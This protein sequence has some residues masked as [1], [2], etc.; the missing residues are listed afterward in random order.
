MYLV[1]R[2]V[3]ADTH[4]FQVGSRISLLE[5]WTFPVQESRVSDRMWEAAGCSS[6]PEYVAANARGRALIAEKHSILERGVGPIAPVQVPNENGVMTTK[7]FAKEPSQGDRK[8]IKVIDKE[9]HEVWGPMFRSKV[10]LPAGTALEIALITPLPN[11][12]AGVVRFNI[13]ETTH[14]GLLMKKE[15]GSLSNGKRVFLIH[16]RDF[17]AAKYHVV[18]P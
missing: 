8:R 13:T 14:P 2:F 18:A 12:S 1:G 6:D 16:G 4:P 7:M 11:F 9:L 15:G 10:T 5:D 3:L 17:E